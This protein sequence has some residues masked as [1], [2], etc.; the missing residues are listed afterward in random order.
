MARPPRYSWFALLI[1]AVACTTSPAASDVQSASPASAVD[2]CSDIDLRDPDGDPLDLNGTWLGIDYGRYVVAQ[3][4]SCVSWVG[5][6]LEVQPSPAEAAVD[7]D[8][9]VQSWESVFD[10][11]LDMDFTINGSWSE[12]IPSDHTQDKHGDLTVS[13]EFVEVDGSLQPRLHV[14]PLDLFNDVWM[15]PSTTV[16]ERRELVGTYEGTE[17]LWVEVDG[18][19]FESWAEWLSF[20]DEVSGTGSS[21]SHS[22]GILDGD[23]QIFVWPGDSVRVDA[24]VSP[25]FGSSVCGSEKTLLLWDIAPAS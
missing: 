8:F 1:I 23:H 21:A 12:V 6:S 16:S 2:G 24:Q 15:A 5:E 3:H 11:E 10:G 9:P 19:R 18:E 25:L 14:P 20:T 13:I 17:C 7:S 22:V 4:G